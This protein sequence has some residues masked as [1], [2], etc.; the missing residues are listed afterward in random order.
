MPEVSLVEAVNLALARAMAEDSRVLVLGEDVA[1]N[2]GVFRATDGLLAR[3][4]S[5]RVFDTPL[6]ELAIA[7]VSVGLAVQGFRPVAEIQ[8]EGF[9]YP[10]LDQLAN[11]AA[12]LR[13]RTR[14]RLTC[15]MVLRVP[16]GGGVHA[17]EHHSDS[18]EAM[19]AHVPGL[20][21]VIPSSPARAYG[22]LLAAIDDPDPVVFFEPK[23]RYR[24]LREAV[25]DDGARLPLDRCFVV[26]EGRDLT[27]VTWG[28]MLGEALEAADAL[29]HDGVTA[30][31]VDVATLKPLDAETIVAS[32]S[33][34]G[35]CLV[36][37]EAPLTA[38]FGGEI[39]ACVAE[40]ALTSLLAPVMRVAGY[41][42]VMPLPRLE[43]HYMPSVSR[44]LAAA[45][46]VMAFA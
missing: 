16:F 1:V 26:R 17:P 32:V 34:T 30:E 39:A 37:H 21:V 9:A 4:G 46:Q 41:D 24:A 22:L 44:V 3:F 10:A 29:W 7:G 5:E 6:A 12:R 28:A 42:T 13:N 35:R 23:R 19:F 15:P 27:I 45:R 25:A 33:K 8:F 43:G 31:V 11:H 18:I 14:G 40:A 20:R 38:G 2:G 36:L